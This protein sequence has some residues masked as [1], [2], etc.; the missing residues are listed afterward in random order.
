MTRLATVSQPRHGRHLAAVAA[1]GARCF[2]LVDKSLVRHVDAS[3]TGR[4]AKCMCGRKR[5]MRGR[6]SSEPL[7]SRRTKAATKLNEQTNPQ[8]LPPS[9]ALAE[10]LALGQGR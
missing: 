2:G 5:E 9:P 4:F 1:V 3:L 7:A 10:L 8:I 6:G